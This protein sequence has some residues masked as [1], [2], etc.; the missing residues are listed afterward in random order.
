MS[1]AE[2][3]DYLHGHD[4]TRDLAERLAERLAEVL[5]SQRPTPVPR[6]PT[7]SLALVPS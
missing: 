7:R 3:L 4:A 2:F 1:T 5:V 6:R